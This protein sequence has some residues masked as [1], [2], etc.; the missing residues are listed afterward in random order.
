MAVKGSIG[1]YHQ[2]IISGWA[3]DGKNP[4]EPVELSLRINNAEKQRFFANEP[5]SKFKEQGIHPTGLC[6]FSVAIDQTN[7]LP[8]EL[9][10]LEIT[11][12]NTEK[13]LAN[14]PVFIDNR[15]KN[16]RVLIVGLN[17]SGTSILTYRIASGMGANHI[18]FEPKSNQGLNRYNHHVKFTSRDKVVTKCL[19]HHGSSNYLTSISQLYDKKIWIVRDPRDVI[20]SSFLYMWYKGH[21]KPIDKFNLAYN[22]VL[23]KE[24]NPEEHSFYET[25]QGTININKYVNERIEPIA[26][27]IKNLGEDWFILKYED[28]MQNKDHELNNYLGFK[29]DRESEVGNQVKRVSRSNSYDNWRSW[30]TNEDV[31]KLSLLFNPFLKKLG[32]N[33]KDWILSSDTDLDPRVGS[34][35]MY[36]LFHS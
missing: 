27:R 16:N 15:G 3:F 21:N 29:I 5:R 12:S 1:R 7:I 9:T 17:K 28:F 18:Y 23:E 2:G 13:N 24:A 19:Y 14:S 36:N 31:E 34:E 22:K 6:G 32:Y 33:D 20:I 11:A 4:N 26:N 30:F 10:S 35:Y 25:I 8:T